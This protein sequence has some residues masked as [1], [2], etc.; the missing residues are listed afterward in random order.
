MGNTQSESLHPSLLEG[1]DL[2]KLIN[3]IK[4]YNLDIGKIIKL[5][6]KGDLAGVANYILETGVE[7]IIG[8]PASGGGNIGVGGKEEEDWGDIS[9]AAGVYG[10]G[11]DW[12]VKQEGRDWE[13]GKRGSRRRSRRRSRKVKRHKSRRGHRRGSRFGAGRPL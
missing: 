3:V 8:L 2:G 4:D 1:F 11:G 6:N 13:F 7:G 5:L 12:D 10:E 9:Q